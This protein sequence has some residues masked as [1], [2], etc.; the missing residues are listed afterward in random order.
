MYINEIQITN[1]LE[2]TGLSM[3]VTPPV[4]CP[5]VFFRHFRIT[6]LLLTK[7]NSSLLSIVLFDRLP[8][9]IVCTKLR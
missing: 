3:T 4:F 1:T 9:K 6:E 5:A 8:F 7:K 2:Q